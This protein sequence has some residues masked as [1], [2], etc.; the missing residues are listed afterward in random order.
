MVGHGWPVG[1]SKST[2]C[3]WETP[4]KYN[5]HLPKEQNTAILKRTTKKNHLKNIIPI[6]PYFC[7]DSCSPEQHDIWDG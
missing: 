2:A 4:K 6:I 1:C 7:A 5:S 3:F